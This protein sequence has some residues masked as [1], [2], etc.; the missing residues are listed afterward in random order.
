MK[1]ILAAALL[2]S[3]PAVARTTDFHH[4]V[5][6]VQENRTPDDLFYPLCARNPCH[7]TPPG[8]AYDVQKSGWLNKEA[9]G[10]VIQPHATP[11]S[12]PYDL[13]HS[14]EAF[15]AM[16]D[17]I[18][19]KS[20]CAMD[21]A[22]DVGCA[23]GTPD[24]RCPADPAFG[25]VDNAAGIITPYLTMVKQYGWANYMFQTNQSD[26]YPAHQFLFGATSAPNGA[27]DAAG[28]FVSELPEPTIGYSG[29]N[30]PKNVR[31]QLIVPNLGEVP[32]NTVFPCYART[33]IADLLDE[34]GRSWRYYTAAGN[35]IWTAPNAI[36]HICQAVGRA[37]KGALWEGNV[38]LNPTDVLTDIADC[39]L[40]SVVWVTPTLQNSDHAKGN[41]GGGPSWVTSI[42]NAIGNSHCGYWADTAIFVTWDDW[43]GWYD[44]VAPPILAGVQGDYQ[45]GFRVPFIVISA[46]TP[47]GYIDNRQYDFGS[48]ARFIE[49]NFGIPEGALDFA[50]ARSA[51]DLTRFFDLGMAP[52][53]F[54]TISAP[55]DAQHFLDDRS[56]LLP[57]DDD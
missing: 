22:A 28:I 37:C 31:A 45:L 6:I 5:L 54:Q 34:A 13:S 15:I 38:D 16:C 2:L 35:S 48:V 26:S 8:H 50:D 21:G 24:A 3:L 10:G 56:P 40:Q 18:P 12:E 4:V 57:P 47:R 51:S 42:V 36:D 20:Q 32:G 52:R 30:S 7:V 29:C 43:G 23:T 25:Y 1:I 17:M 41:T 39:A 9:A 11:L 14:H 33:T 53:S 46:Y 49:Q 55:L 27:D 19:G 44:H